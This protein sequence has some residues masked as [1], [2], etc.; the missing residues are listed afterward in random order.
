[1]NNPV[2][3]PN[4][5]SLSD[6]GEISEVLVGVLEAAD[7]DDLDTI[8]RV[9]SGAKRD[10]PTGLPCKALECLEAMAEKELAERDA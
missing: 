5:H 8:R 3:F 1:M 7:T 6:A 4:P 10:N 2:N 9:A